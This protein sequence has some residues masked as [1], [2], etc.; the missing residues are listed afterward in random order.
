MHDTILILDFGGQYTHLIARRIREL[1][2]YSEIA[3]FNAPVDEFKRRNVK[4]VI[5]SGGPRSV[6]E[7]GSP[8]VGRDFFRW[9]REE[10]VP[11]LGICYG[12]QLIAHVLGGEIEKGEKKEYGRTLLYVE[13][14]DEIFR[15]LDIV[16]T[17]WMSHGD[18]VLSLPEGFKVIGRTEN[19]P[20][21]AYA[22][23]EEQIYGVQFHPEV[24]HTVKGVKILENFALRVC[25][26]RASWVVEN[27]IEEAVNEVRRKVEGGGN[28]IMAVSGGVDSTVAATIIHR[29]VGERL[30][31]VFVDNGLLRK[32]EA[33]EVTRTFR[34]RLGF[35]NFHVV[36][37]GGLFLQRLRGVVDPEEK[38]RIIAHT[39][40]EVFEEKARELEAKYG[41]FRF[42]GQGTIYPDR[43][44][45]AATSSAAARIKSHHN[46]TLPEE[47]KLEVIEPLASLY[48]D[49]VRRL[50]EKLGIPREILWRHP[51]PGPSLAVRVLGEVTG[52]KLEIVREADA[53]V[54]EEVRKAGI[55][56]KLW[57]AFAVLLP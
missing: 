53:I 6:Y 2:V 41:K 12:H 9:C 21:A 33:D 34:E 29:A 13:D 11:V 25:G 38:R 26:C 30:H 14:E 27:W 43:V 47:M 56:D 37:A 49:E 23:V 50:G 32:G 8:K 18:Q 55:Y 45:S 7:E 24:A 19:T 48:K 35:K 57:Q 51:F 44:E 54:E 46:V 10:G 16:E 36:N 40:I 15:G 42:L 20:I 22:N 52:E 1:N 28:I 3:P 39:F 17:V 4:G 5:L 31:C